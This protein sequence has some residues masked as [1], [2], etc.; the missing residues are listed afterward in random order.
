M[1]YEVRLTTEAENDLRGIFEYIAF[2]LQS[3]QNAQASPLPSGSTGR[4]LQSSP[5]PYPGSEQ[6]SLSPLSKT[7]IKNTCQALL[8]V[9]L[10]GL[11]SYPK[12]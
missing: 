9:Y 6:P 10:A 2:E 1:N 4:W 8:A 5:N 11:N 3:P 7:Y 12:W